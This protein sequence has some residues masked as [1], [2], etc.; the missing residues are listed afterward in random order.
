M[1]HHLSRMDSPSRDSRSLPVLSGI[2]EQTVLCNRVLLCPRVGFAEDM[3]L[4]E[5]FDAREQWPNCPTIKQI[6]DQGS[7]GSCWVRPCWWGRL[8]EVWLGC[9]GVSREVPDGTSHI[10][11]SFFPSLRFL[12]LVVGNCCRDEV[13]DGHTV[14]GVLRSRSR[15]RLWSRVP[16]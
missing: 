4:P 3:D 1:S 13:D 10:G 14:S 2:G 8:P 5:N 6:R 15:N 9:D 7:C 12:I 16:Q 11:V